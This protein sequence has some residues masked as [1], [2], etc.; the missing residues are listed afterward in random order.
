MP[1]AN[2][3]KAN[4]D[5]YDEWRFV[6]EAAN[7]VTSGVPVGNLNAY[8]R[9]NDATGTALADATTNGNN[10]TWSGTLGNAQWG[11]GRL[12]GGGVFNGTDRIVTVPAAAPLDVSTALTIALWL[13]PGA[14]QVGFATPL[15][16]SGAYWLEGS[17]TGNNQYTFFLNNGADRQVGFVQL[18]ASTWNHLVLSYDGTTA[19]CY[20]NGVAAATAAVAS[21]VTVNTNA[22]VLGNRPGFTRFF[23]GVLDELG[24]WSR[25]LAPEEVASVYNAGA[26]AAYG[27]P[28][29][30]IGPGAFA[31]GGGNLGFFGKAPATQAATPATLADVIALLQ[32]YGLAP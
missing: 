11:T 10:G 31:H 1:V 8:W 30:R 25:A 20:L 5:W 28:A 9:F 27:I 12:L 16:K 26:G 21:P 19:V 15:A 18:A 22:L 6:L 3:P 29:N 7:F 2:P 4:T 23:A 24:I 14:T 32:R 17:G 13:N